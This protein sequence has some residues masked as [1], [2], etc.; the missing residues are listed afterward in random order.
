VIRVE[1]RLGKLLDRVRND[2]VSGASQTARYVAEGLVEYLD[3]PWADPGEVARFAVR[4]FRAR[5]SMA[6]L[7]V[8]LNQVL[9]DLDGRGREGIVEARGHVVEFLQRERMADS[10]ISRSFAA[11][12]TTGDVLTISNSSTVAS[13][14][15]DTVDRGSDRTVVVMESRP[16]SEGRVLARRLSESGIGCQLVAD[17]M[18]CEAAER[19]GCAVCGVDCLV[20]G[21][22]VNKVGTMALA[23]ACREAEVPLHALTSTAKFVGTDISDLMK[24]RGMAGGCVARRQVFERAPLRLF[25]DIVT[26]KGS[27]RPEAIAFP[28][29]PYP[30][31]KPGGRGDR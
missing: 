7:F 5:R 3:G 24:S 1:A 12:R 19:C 4:A 18:V 27:L 13:V 29:G 25:T 22:V 21:Y 16:G 15:I 23:L 6:P 26:E 17:T 10:M 31:L 28:R 14:L 30:L 20:P 2:H 9:T 8:L 11:L